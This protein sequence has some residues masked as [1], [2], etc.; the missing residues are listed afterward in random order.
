MVTRQRTLIVFMNE[1]DD[2]RSSP[3]GPTAATMYEVD[4]DA[5]E[6]GVVCRLLRDRGKGEPH[7]ADDATIRAWALR[8]K[9]PVS[10]RG[11]VPAQIRR[12]YDQEHSDP[13]GPDTV[14]DVATDQ[15][16]PENVVQLKRRQD[17][18]ET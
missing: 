6:A 14:A 3:G 15:G 18:A 2:Q 16:D 5:D 8:R 9:L 1:D 10:A 13:P 7:E 17:G 12:Q 4:L 11:R